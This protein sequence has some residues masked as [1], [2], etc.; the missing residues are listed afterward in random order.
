SS[1]N[2]Y[3]QSLV[4]SMI[5]HNGIESTENWARGL[6]ANFARAPKGGDRDQIKAVAVGECDIALVNTYYLGGM[7]HSTLEDEKQ[8]AEKVSLFWPNQ[9]DRGAHFNVSGAGITVSAK[10]R[11]AAV[12]L[13]EFLSG[14][15]AQ[16]WYAETNYEFPV[17]PGIRSGDTLKQWGDYIADDINLD[18]L[19]QYNA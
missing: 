5:A 3:N 18:Q 17:K 7:L 13:I 16:A 9:N 6:V 2:P 11:E 12:R 8:A 1:S 19:G 10:N 14:D 4:A 15:E